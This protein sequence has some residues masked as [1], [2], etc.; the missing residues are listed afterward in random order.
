MP[1][2][3]TRKAASKR[4]K[5]TGTGKILIGHTG[6]SHLKTKKRRKDK[7]RKGLTQVL[8]KGHKKT[9]LHM[10]PGVSFR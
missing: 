10:I 3:K 4:I 8:F 7:R 6:T 5:I 1:K 2:L 9:I